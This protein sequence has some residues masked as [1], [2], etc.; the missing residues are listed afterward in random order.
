M[1]KVLIYGFRPF[2]K[3]KTNISA[4]IIKR[5]KEKE[6]T[7]VILP[8]VYKKKYIINRV[9]KSKPDIIIGLGQTAGEKFLTIER[10]AKNIYEKE[11]PTGRKVINPKGQKE[12]FL[13]WKPKTPRGVRISYDP[14]EYL[15]NFTMYCLMNYINKNNLKTKFTFIHIPNDYSLQKATKIIQEIIS[16]I[17]NN[18]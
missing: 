6:I 11:R 5:I 4:E 12:I 9:R 1:K 17:K 7:K 3:Y 13:N 15:C 10:K 8:I 16:E 18:N 14:G 2:K